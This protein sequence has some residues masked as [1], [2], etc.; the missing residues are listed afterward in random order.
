MPA[1]T[2]HNAE[3]KTAAVEIRTLT[4]SGKQVTLAVFRQL[5]EEP[6]VAKDGTL[7]GVPW[8]TVNYHPVPKQCE[9]VRDHWHVVWQ[10]GSELLRST[11]TKSV[12]WSGESFW[13]GS[14]PD[15]LAAHVRAILSGA[16]SKFWGGKIPTL[17]SSYNR[18]ASLITSER[19]IA[20]VCIDADDEVYSAIKADART[21]SLVPIPG[22]GDGRVWWEEARLR[23]SQSAAL[24]ASRHLVDLA[25][26]DLPDKQLAD[27]DREFDAEV[28]AEL[29]RRRRHDQVRHAIADLPQLF[30]AV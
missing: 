27:L 15:L 21:G 29:Q 25:V 11:V 9:D 26:A 28:D 23:V 4:I 16:G 14:G 24:R 12:R 30:I 19:G 10:K 2:V 5:R 18:R 20:V 7:N 8:G 17:D 13:P 6:L 1:L 3:I 22:E